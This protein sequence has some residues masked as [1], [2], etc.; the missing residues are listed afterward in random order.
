MHK[1]RGKSATG[2]ALRSFPLLKIEDRRPAKT[3]Y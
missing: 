1:K 3:I 2:Y